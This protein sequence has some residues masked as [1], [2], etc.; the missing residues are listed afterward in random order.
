[1]VAM[2]KPSHLGRFK[3]IAKLLFKYGRGELVEAAGLEMP[4]IRNGRNVQHAQPTPEAEDLAKDLEK[5][6]PVFIKIGQLFSTRPDILPA[7]FVEALARLQDDV[8]PIPFEDVERV[9]REELG[10]R[11]T[12]AFKTFDR[13]PISAASLG[14]VHRAEM[15]DGRLV[16]VK[17][18][19]PGIREKMVDDLDSLHDVADFFDRHTE[20]GKKHEFLKVLEEFRKTLMHELDYRLEAQNLKTLGA[21]LAEYRRIVVPQPVDDYTTTRMLTMQYIPGYKLP[22]LSPLIKTEL[23]GAELAEQLFQ[24]YLKQILVDG[25]FHADPHPG[26]ILL[27]RE[28]NIALIDLGMVGHLSPRLQESLLQI[29][30][31]TSEGRGEDAADHMVAVSEK[32]EDADEKGFKQRVIELVSQNRNAS[33]QQI[34]VGRVV[35]GMSRLAADSGLRVPPETATLAKT[36]LNLDEVGRILDPNFNPNESIR[37]NATSLMQRR[38]AKSVTP[39]SIYSGILEA[40]DLL[41]HIPGKISKI[42]DNVADNNMKLN[43]DAIDEQYL[44][45]GL[46]KIANRITVGLILAALIVGAALLM[47]VETPLKIFGYPGLAMIFFLLAAAGGVILLFQILFHDEP[48]R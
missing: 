20:I 11:L 47:R 18:Q 24:A 8:E 16:A 34:A 17:V 33:L 31:A 25:F 35:F 1:M 23:D 28:S 19:R 48:T 41:T 5:M 37:R 32:K 2:L 3:D 30:L 4:D 36:L 12:R 7:P 39:G 10:M 21:N 9:I 46:Q 22:A 42:L 6:G 14:Q 29:I 26:N 40:K 43:V 38:V 44:M 13:E 27:T 45:A 15:R